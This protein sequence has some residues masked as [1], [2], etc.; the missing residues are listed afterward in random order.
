MELEREAVST[1]V[2]AD[3]ARM[4]QGV[5]LINVRW[6]LWVYRKRAVGASP[7]PAPLAQL[8]TVKEVRA[9]VE[10]SL[11]VV[12]RGPFWCVHKGEGFEIEF[13]IGGIDS[14][15]DDLLD[16]INIVV[17]GRGDALPVLVEF[18]RRN[19]LTLCDLRTGEELEF[20]EHDGTAPSIGEMVARLR[21]AP[22][23]GG[24]SAPL[25]VPAGQPQEHL[26]THFWSNPGGE[27]FN[28]VAVEGNTLL[29]GRVASALLED[30]MEQYRLRG[31]VRISAHALE[32]GSQRRH[33]T[34]LRSLC[35]RLDS[36]ACELHFHGA[37]EP[38]RVLFSS[39]LAK[40]RFIEVALSR[41]P[42]PRK[43]FEAERLLDGVNLPALGGA[44]ALAGASLVWP[45]TVLLIL[46]A[47]SA[48]ATAV[49]LV[50]YFIRGP[51]MYEVYEFGEA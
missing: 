7:H 24:G 36:P 38:T 30:L 37:A 48:V 12:W 9:M 5:A 42:K 45:S 25:P 15:D 34:Q 20:F 28:L 14:R 23:R 19:R 21:T 11:P 29:F 43:T 16:S 31:K 41:V 35:D 44:A 46:T 22:A 50:R 2:T 13:D 51:Q 3:I 6:D 32:L 47:A 26:Y 10:E 1:G 39:P 4:A 17:R 18:S 40:A 33:F 8:G 27:P 49:P